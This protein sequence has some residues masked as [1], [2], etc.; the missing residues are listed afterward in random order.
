MKEI[1]VYGAI[2]LSLVHIIYVAFLEICELRKDIPKGHACTK[3]KR[4]K[5]SAYIWNK[6]YFQQ[7]KYC[8]REKCPGFICYEN[9][10]PIKKL[11]ILSVLEIIIKQMPALA[12]LLLLFLQII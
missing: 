5:C 2:I 4:E 6:I 3:L 10:E 1:I 12:T 11:S 8:V 7:K 9:G